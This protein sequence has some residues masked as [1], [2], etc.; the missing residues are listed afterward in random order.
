M[1]AMLLG[2]ARRFVVL[3][4][5]RRAALVAAAALVPGVLFALSWVPG[6]AASLTAGAGSDPYVNLN[7]V[8]CAAAGNCSAVGSYIYS[9]SRQGLL[10][11]E[12]RSRWSAG[13]KATLPAGAR[14]HAVTVNSVSCASA[15]NCS[16]VGSYTDSSHHR[17]GLLLSETHGR[18]VPGVKAILPAGVGSNSGVALRSVFCASVGNCSAVGSY[19]DSSGFTQGVLLSETRGGWARGVEASLPA[20]AGS[21]PGVLFASLSCASFENCSAVGSYTDGS[22]HRQGLLLSETGGRWARGMEGDPARERRVEP[23]GQPHLGVVRLGGELQRCRPLHRYVGRA[24]GGFAYRDRGPVG[25]ERRGDPA[26]GRHLCQAPVGVVRLGGELQRRRLVHRQLAGR[27]AGAVAHRD[28]RQMVGREGGDP[29]RGRRIHS[30][31]HPQIGVVRLGGELQ[32]RRLLHRQLVPPAGT[33]AERDGRQLGGGGKIGGERHL[34]PR[35]HSRLGVVQLGREL[36]RRRLLRRG[37]AFGH[38]DPRQV[39]G[40]EGGGPAPT[41]VTATLISRDLPPRDD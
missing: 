35:C 15:G 39:V 28:P 30:P 4:G 6:A 24:A 17:Q 8:S 13:V 19:T 31:G 34:E 21:N 20:D 33:F 27:C 37:R 18:W 36:Q 40:R 3:F 23:Q 14:S 22:H 29:A 11:S 16:A 5:V 38:R 12:T 9:T 32:R 10:L 2:G 1:I 25:T 41:G 26:R 7:S